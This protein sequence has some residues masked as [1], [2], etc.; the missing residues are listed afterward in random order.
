MTKEQCDDA[1]YIWIIS[2][3]AKIIPAPYV[4]IPSIGETLDF[5]YYFPAQNRVIVRI[6]DLSA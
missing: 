5:S 1:G 3:Q 6:F 2:N 4:L